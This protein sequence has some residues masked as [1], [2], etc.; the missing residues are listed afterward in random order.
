MK[1]QDMIKLEGSR[2]NSK[3]HKEDET[4]DSKQKSRT[5]MNRSSRK[6]KKNE[7]TKIKE[8]DQRIAPGNTKQ[9]LKLVE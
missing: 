8:Y 9:I 1:T 6:R 2:Y 5:T 4:I 7:I 3:Q